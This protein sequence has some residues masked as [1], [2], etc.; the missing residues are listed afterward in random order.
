MP[1]PCFLNDLENVQN[2]NKPLSFFSFTPFEF[3]RDCQLLLE[4]HTSGLQNTVKQVCKTSQDFLF[5]C[6]I[7]TFLISSWFSNRAFKFCFRFF[8]S[9]TLN[10]VKLT[11]SANSANPREVAP[12]FNMRITRTES[13]LVCKEE[14][15]IPFEQ[16]LKEKNQFAHAQYF[17][18]VV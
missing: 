13:R 10:G 1:F 3:L 12:K 2:A 11:P 16:Y 14:Q 9:V 6:K 17:F 8:F 5:K 7:T 15:K 4:L 18:T